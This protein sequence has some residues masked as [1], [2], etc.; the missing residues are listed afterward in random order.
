MTTKAEPVN[1]KPVI[2]PARA[3]LQFYEAFLI[4]TEGSRIS[5]GTMVGKVGECLLG[6]AYKRAFSIES[7][8]TKVKKI[9]LEKVNR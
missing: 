4:T 5:L 3:K 1:E 7:D 9:K 8:S 6:A 2:L